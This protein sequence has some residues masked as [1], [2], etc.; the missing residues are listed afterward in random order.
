M[1][2]VPAPG[3]R[4]P[5][6]YECVVGHARTAPL[7]HTFR[8]RTYLWLVDLDTM[9]ALPRALRF[10]ARFDAADHFDGA[11]GAAGATGATGATIRQGLDAFLADRGVHLDGGRVVMLAHARVLGHVFNPLTLYWCYRRDGTPACVV[12]EVHNT[13]GERHCYLLHTDEHGCAEVPKE[14]YVSPFFPVDGAYRMRLP[15]PGERLDLTVS[16]RRGGTRPFTATVRGTRRPATVR[17]LLAAAVRHPWSTA[18]VSAGIRRHGIRLFL[19]RLPIQP[20]PRHRPQTPSRPR[21][22]EIS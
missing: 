19:R 17:S 4:A 3:P 16:L 18:A 9:P 12:A 6:L 11:T 5:A 13:Y 8:H 15:E 14:F 21:D 22:Q 2:S 1:T 20:R 7:R 10:L